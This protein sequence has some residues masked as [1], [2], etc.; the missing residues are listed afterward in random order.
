VKVVFDYE[1]NPN[2]PKGGIDEVKN[3][4]LQIRKF[5]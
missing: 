1:E 5:I 4:N 2:I 3:K